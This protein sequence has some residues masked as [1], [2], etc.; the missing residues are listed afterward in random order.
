MRT[1]E[2]TI[3]AETS[4]PLDVSIIIPC[5]NEE[6]AVADCVRSARTWLDGSGFTGEVIVVDNNSTDRTSE[7]ARKAG[8]RVLREEAR[9][10]GNAFRT[11]VQASRG[12]IIVMSD[13]D[14]TYD[15]TNLDPIVDPLRDG[16][17]MV[18]GNRLKGEMEAKSMPWLHKRI[19]NP[20][21]NLVI[22]AIAR[23]RFGDVLSG[24][25]GFTREAWDTMSPVAVGFE[26]E[27][28]ICLRAGRND[29]K[30]KE[31]P[32]PYAVRR[33]PSKL[34]G[35]TH[36]WAIARFIM[37][38]S[39]DLIFIYPGLLAI[40][41]GVVSLAIGALS[42][43]GVDVGSVRW[44]PVFAGG[45]LVPG[46]VAFLT[47]GIASKWL[48]WRRGVAPAGRI[49]SILRNETVP[50]GDYFLLAGGGSL[51]AGLSLDAYLLFTWTILNDEPSLALGLGAVA[52]TLVVAGL[53]LIVASMLIGVLRARDRPQTARERESDR[54]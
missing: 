41:L 10:K 5:L 17:D 34:R 7:V 4:E 29:L 28:E 54:T 46:G 52:Q 22:G 19:G 3:P 44:Q 39:A 20:L 45:I 33:E 31:V 30:V 40:A 53:N 1:V 8:A 49:V 11:G 51:V 32:V 43:S 26:L 27:S 13:G 42:S 18:I 2:E 9:G 37:L 14:G 6:K 35:L 50:V 36:G 21:F 24:L 48:A 16:Y 38:E 25:R 12:R 15:L 23:K 47:L